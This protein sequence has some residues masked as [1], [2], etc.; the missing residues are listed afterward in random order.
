MNAKD[1][2]IL[3][4]MPAKDSATRYNYGLNYALW[5]H[6][7]SH[8][9]L[10]KQVTLEGITGKL[11]SKWLR[12]YEINC[13]YLPRHGRWTGDPRK[14]ILALVK[15]TRLPLI[16]FNND[17]HKANNESPL[18]S[19]IRFVF[20]RVNDNRGQWRAENSGA[21][22][23]WS[24]DLNV[25]HP[26]FGG[27]IPMSMPCHIN[28]QYP[29]RMAIRQEFSS[30]IP[31][32]KVFG[33]AYAALLRRSRTSVVCAGGKLCRVAPGK[34]LEVVACGTLPVC[35]SGLLLL[36]RYFPLESCRRFSTLAEL[37]VILEW[38]MAYPDQVE[39]AQK[40]VYRHIASHS[41]ELQSKR[42]SDFV[43]SLVSGTPDPCLLHQIQHPLDYVL[44]GQAT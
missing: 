39:T 26:S 29:L 8:V 23:P 38:A 24:V 32:G 34:L 30:L 10:F 7:A 40:E 11:L 21:W 22:L 2:R 42:V 4:V 18:Y 17:D 43:A 33:D 27:D 9:G 6:S 25:F 36:D 15:A 1:L 13:I 5:C 3:A 37:R 12:K 28:P 14:R 19:G 44:P 16:M 35:E 41:V 20:E 31:A